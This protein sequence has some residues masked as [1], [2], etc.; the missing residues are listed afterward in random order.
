MSAADP[1][2]REA[3]AAVDPAGM[4]DDVLAQPGQLG[5]ALWRADSA[6][7]RSGSGGRLVV[8]GMGGSAIGGDLAAAIQDGYLAH[9]IETVRGY[10]L[11]PG[12]AAG[13]FVLAASYSG[14]TEETL[15]CV[16]HAVEAGLGIGAV[17]TGGA[18]AAAAREHGAPVMGVPSGMQPRAAVVYMTVAALYA[19][20]ACGAAPAL[21]PGVV[22]DAAGLLGD[23]ARDWGPDAPPDS[24]AKRLA[25]ALH[26]TVPVVIG[27][28]RTA[29][30]AR[31]WKTQV[32]ENASAPAFWSELPEADHNEI[33]GYGAPLSAVFLD[34]DGL[35]PR[36]RR[37]I[38]LTAGLLDIP[39]ERVEARGETPFARVMSLV[40]LGDLVSVYLAVL[41]G[42][43][44]TPVPSID[45]LKEALG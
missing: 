10:D 36:L 19:A 45:R 22:E 13:T 11:G 35:D 17:T 25:S 41:A 39:V 21:D 27:A 3:I 20:A 15:A 37:R 23:L 31:R 30:A 38:D 8:A 5:D 42:E 18:L 6:M 32:N 4:L 9:P 7:F 43:D 28:G 34:D 33:C 26:G 24:E 12:R 44:P 16:G 29:A 2:T 1:L 14:E 40:L